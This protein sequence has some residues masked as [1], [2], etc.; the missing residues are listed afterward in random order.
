M[1]SGRPSAPALPDEA[2]AELLDFEVT[3]ELRGLGA[4]RAEPV[5]RHLV[6]AAIYL[7]DDPALALAHARAASALASRIAAVREAVGLAAYHAGEF[8]TA[9]A[10]LRA[11]RRLDGSPRHLAVMADA[12]RGLGRP[13]RALLLARDPAAAELDEASR[14]ELLIVVSG[15]RR[16]LG[17]PAAAVLLLQDEAA[18]TRLEPWTPRLWYA[19]AEALLAAGRPTDA[20]RWFVSV[21][22]VDHDEETDAAERALLLGGGEPAGEIEPG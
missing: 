11:A 3:R 9:L 5:A 15:A 12:E 20:A 21:A 18:S 8:T 17:E 6:A 10:E 22:T 14:V 2:R 13:E 16:D 4:A 19:Y 1:R 7:D